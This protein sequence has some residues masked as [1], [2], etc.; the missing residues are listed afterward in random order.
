[1]PDAIEENIRLR[2]K[3][4]IPIA[5][6]E[7][8]CTRWDFKQLLDSNSCDIWQ[9]D[10]TVLGGISEWNKIVTIASVWGI[11]IAPHAMHEIHSQLVAASPNSDPYIV[12]YFD[13]KGDIVNYGKLLKNNCVAKDGFLDISKNPGVGIDFD[14]AKI[15]KYRIR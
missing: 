3:T 11:A 6:G 1:M 7:I 5:N 15:D 10:V 14:E 12:E 9:P 13:T 4:N 2:E 8:L